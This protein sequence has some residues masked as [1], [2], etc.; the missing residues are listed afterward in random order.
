MYGKTHVTL[1]AAIWTGSMWYLQTPAKATLV[2]LSGV[3]LGSLL[4][5]ID[6][7][8]SIMGRMLPFISRP[9]NRFLGHRTIT[10]TIW[11]IGLWFGVFYGYVQLRGADPWALFLFGIALGNALHIFEDKFSRAG[12]VL[13][14]P[15][16]RY[17]KSKRGIS[18][19][20]GHYW[21]YR[22]GGPF[23]R[24]IMVLAI[25]FLF[26]FSVFYIIRFTPDHLVE[27][28]QLVQLVTIN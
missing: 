6:T 3:I 19:A 7:P 2:G 28:L 9:L 27:H 17:N 8:T 11:A 25:G 1:N 24:F 18:Y 4:P 26:I 23:E 10:H 14:Y 21:G 15:L 16:I 20:P 5:D 13:T 12:V 22:V